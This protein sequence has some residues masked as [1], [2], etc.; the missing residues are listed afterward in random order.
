[1]T[2]SRQEQEEGGELDSHE[3][4]SPEKIKNRVVVLG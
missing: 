2:E 3:E 1:M 4:A